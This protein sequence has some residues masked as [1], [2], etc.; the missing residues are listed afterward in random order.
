MSLESQRARSR[1]RSHT[2]AQR[3]PVRGTVCKYRAVLCCRRWN[4]GLIGA[5]LAA[6]TCG[7]PLVVSEA[8]VRDQCW[9]CETAKVLRAKR[10]SASLLSN[11]ARVICCLVFFRVCACVRECCT[12]VSGSLPSKEPGQRSGSRARFTWRARGYSLAQS[13]VAGARCAAGRA[14]FSPPRTPSAREKEIVIRIG[15]RWQ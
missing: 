12:P 11:R 8:V 6:P 7:G 2:S 14:C 3:A 1:A 15:C 9:E 4:G 13:L 5:S 10:K